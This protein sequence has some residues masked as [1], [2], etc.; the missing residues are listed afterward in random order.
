MPL[1]L[2]FVD[3]YEA[4]APLSGKSFYLPPR[5]FQWCLEDIHSQDPSTSTR[6][7]LPIPLHNLVVQFFALKESLADT[8]LIHGWFREEDSS[9]SS[10]DTRLGARSYGR[11]DGTAKPWGPFYAASQ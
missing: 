4:V 9:W 7:S 10:G 6:S 2:A 8:C 5:A 11:Y 3:G 1:N